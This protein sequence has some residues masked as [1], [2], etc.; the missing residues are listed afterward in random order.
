MP[1]RIISGLLGVETNKV[2]LSLNGNLTLTANFEADGAPAITRVTSSGNE[3]QGV[4][5]AS[6]GASYQL[7]Y[8]ENLKDWFP[9]NTII[10]G[11]D[12]KVEFG[13]TM[14]VDHAFYRLRFEP[15]D[16]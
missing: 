15:S 14:N 9:I 16:P 13:Q 7:E 1:H 6:A 8:S 10:G 2:S 12:G 3:I 4:A 11:P 5:Q